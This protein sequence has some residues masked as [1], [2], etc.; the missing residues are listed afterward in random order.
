MKKSH[1]LCLYYLPEIFD[2][3]SRQFGQFLGGKSKLTVP[4]LS[5]ATAAG[6]NRCS[7]E[8]GERWTKIVLEMGKAGHGRGRGQRIHCAF[9]GNAGEGGGDNQ[10]EKQFCQFHLI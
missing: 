8:R 7:V 10:V 9:E 1:R 2:C 6:P 3:F 5:I 4:G